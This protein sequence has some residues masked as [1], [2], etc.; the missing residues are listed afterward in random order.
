MNDNSTLNLMMKARKS[1]HEECENI[2]RCTG[3]GVDPLFL[4]VACFIIVAGNF[5]ANKSGIEWPDVE[6]KCNA[7]YWLQ[8]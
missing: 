6:M 1:L 8:S 7:L 3:M 4:K 5:A 2:M